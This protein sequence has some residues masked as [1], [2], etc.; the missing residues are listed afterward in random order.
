MLAEK[1]VYN[2]TRYIHR[3][4]GREKKRLWGVC[5]NWKETHKKKGEGEM[6][7]KE[8]VIRPWS[9]FQDAPWQP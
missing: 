8:R 7:R 5:L 4:G 1:Q 2:T 3:E 6:A 9:V